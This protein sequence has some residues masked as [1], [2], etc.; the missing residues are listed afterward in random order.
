MPG[1]AQSRGHALAGIQGSAGEAI[2]ESLDSHLRGEK[3]GGAVEFLRFFGDDFA[4]F[5]VVNR[6]AVHARGFARDLGGAAQG[7]ADG[8]G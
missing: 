6:R 7:A 1:P 8:G 5:P 3:T 2:T 4:V